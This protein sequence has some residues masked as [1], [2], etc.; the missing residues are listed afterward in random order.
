MPKFRVLESHYYQHK[1]PLVALDYYDQHSHGEDDFSRKQAWFYSYGD[2]EIEQEF[3]EGLMAVFE[4]LFLQDDAEWD[5]ITLYPTHAQGEVNPNLRSLFLDISGDTG[6]PMEQVLNRTETVR[7]NHIIENEKS[8]VVNLEG[9]IAV[10][11]DLTGKNVILVDNIALSGVSMIH[12]ANMLK[13]NGAENV[14]AISIGTALEHKDKTTEIE[15]GQNAT[16]L[17][18]RLDQGG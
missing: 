18:A 8:K 14:F 15:E 1:V 13:K 16:D 11:R 9:S 5:M 12:G 2:K 6:I 7:E 10:N 17:L 4:M 3:R